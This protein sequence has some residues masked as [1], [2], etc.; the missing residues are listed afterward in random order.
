[1]MAIYSK[2]CGASFGCDVLSLLSFISSTGFSLLKGGFSMKSA[3]MSIHA[4]LQNREQPSVPNNIIS[5]KITTV[6]T[7]VFLSCIH[8]K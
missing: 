7:P 1:M 3:D 5:R 6:L 4:F 8:S 2:I